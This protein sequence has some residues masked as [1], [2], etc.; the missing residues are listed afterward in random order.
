VIGVVLALAAA[1]V[2]VNYGDPDRPLRAVRAELARGRPVT[3]I[4]ASGPPRW[5]RVRAGD[6]GTKIVTADD[7][8]FTVHSWDMGMI[9]L[10]PEV[11]HDKFRFR[12]KVRH[13]Q[14]DPAGQVGLYV[15][16][17]GYGGSKRET[18]LFVGMTFNDVLS[19]HPTPTT[20]EFEARFPGPRDNVVRLGAGVNG[21]L[22][23]GDR[24]DVLPNVVAGA[25]FQP[26]G[27]FADTWRE[28][29]LVVTPDGVTGTWEGR[30]VGVLPSQKAV[31]HL[32]E[33]VTHQRG[34]YPGDPFLLGMEPAYS[35]RG[36]VGL[37]LFHGSASFHS[38]VIETLEKDL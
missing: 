37:F 35:P 27:V 22:P 5:S 13:E 34:R 31:A 29:E 18:D 20:P 4:P 38:A 24:W 19:E 11:P 33:Q 30:P 14:S 15:A 12:V 36:G 1:G 17:R 32:M 7:G 16:R 6:S 25:A 26:R 21:E 23:N 8:R 3:L 28:L 2:A 10:L 9:E